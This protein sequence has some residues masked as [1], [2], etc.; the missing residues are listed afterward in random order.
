LGLWETIEK[1]E[2]NGPV[3]E[4]QEASAM[5]MLHSYMSLE[6]SGKFSYGKAKDLWYALHRKYNDTSRSAIEAIKD[7][8]SKVLI[9]DGNI[10]AFIDEMMTGIIALRD[11]DAGLDEE[12]ECFLILK[13]LTVEPYLSF[14]A[15]MMATGFWNLEEMLN[16]L[17]LIPK[18]AKKNYAMVGE[19]NAPN[20]C[21]RCANGSK[22]WSSSCPLITCHK[23]GQNGH[24]KTYCKNKAPF[25]YSWVIDSGASFTMTNDLSHLRNLKASDEVITSAN[26]DQIPV[27]AKGDIKIGKSIVKNVRYVPDLVNPLFSVISA[28]ED[29]CKVIMTKDKCIVEKDGHEL[30]VAHKDPEEGGL[31]R[32]VNCNS[33]TEHKAYAFAA[34]RASLQDWHR[35][36]GHLCKEKVEEITRD[37]KVDGIELTN[38]NWS[39]C[40]DCAFGKTTRTAQDRIANR[41]PERPGDIISADIIGPIK[42][43][44]MNGARYV[45]VIIDHYTS[46]TDIR[47]FA[48]K[49]AAAVAEHLEYFINFIENQSGNRVKILRTDG[50]YAVSEVEQLVS[51][52]GIVHEMTAPYSPA[53][54]GKV[55]RKNR[56]LIETARTMMKGKGVPKKYWAYAVATACFLQNRTL[57]GTTTRLTPHE[58][59]FGTKPDLSLIRQFGSKCWVLIEG[60]KTKLS[61]RSTEGRLLG[62][63]LNSESYIVL[64][65]T[66]QIV[67]S[68]N[69]R[70]GEDLTEDWFSESENEFEQA[71]FEAE[72][73]PE[74]I[75][76]NQYSFPNEY[77]SE[78]YS[79]QIPHQRPSALIATT[80]LTSPTISQALNGPD[81]ALWKEAI[82]KEMAAHKENGTFDVVDMPKGKTIVGSKM[83]LTTKFN[84]KGEIATYKARF[85]AQGFTQQF[86]IDFNDVYAPVCKSATILTLLTKAAHHD[87]EIHQ[88][89]VNTAFLNAELKEEIYVRPPK[90]STEYN[91]KAFKL[92]KALYG[93]KQADREWYLLLRKT[94]ESFGWRASQMDECLFIRSINCSDEYLLVYVDDIILISFSLER[95]SITKGEIMSKFKSKDLG[96]VRFILGIEV[97]RDRTART[98]H[99]SQEGYLKRVLSRFDIS[100]TEKSRSPMIAGSHPLKWKGECPKEEQTLYLEM[101][102]SL[103]HLARFTRPD[104]SLSVG[105]AGRFSSNPGPDHFKMVKKIL[106]YLNETS[107]LGLEIGGKKVLDLNGF[108]DS[109]WAGDVNDR[110]STSGYEFGLATV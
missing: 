99:L 7:Q 12:D 40:E 28:V 23:C 60:H 101:V 71:P 30:L 34:V 10:E 2:E 70:F 85:V 49:E 82:G 18:P 96:E 8:M 86:G 46:Y 102:G 73:E 36:L 6:I 57:P 17:K 72:E 63:E 97:K 42:P 75:D 35:R 11:R 32:I 92:N 47:C 25:N 108:C 79:E 14:A 39:T 62:Y 61:D 9:K 84:E 31:F 90:H 106:F 5:A 80:E 3:T 77:P 16:R 48:T 45:S 87:L 22:H 4:K 33:S 78:E 38:H 41:T 69:V 59:L 19:N 95:I 15:G 37:E 91:G 66:K 50:A 76:I 13:K 26:G 52:R 24:I 64:L 44:S 81:C 103:L 94:L 105:I 100:P 1:C 65:S 56:S 88:M 98:M 53:G 43:P 51:S 58:S 109:D 54:N 110:R 20:E 89:D 67:A 27:A 104:I 29:G 93:L 68:R 74:D 21:R 55:E 107:N 83:V